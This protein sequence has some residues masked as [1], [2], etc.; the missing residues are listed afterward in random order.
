MQNTAL[1]I[2][3][4]RKLVR[5]ANR[6][7][8]EAERH[9]LAIEQ[10]VKNEPDDAT[11]QALYAI[12]LQNAQVTLERECRR[13][14]SMLDHKAFATPQRA[15][16]KGAA[17]V[18]TSELRFL[19]KQLLGVYSSALAKVKVKLAMVQSTNN[20]P[21]LTAD[22]ISALQDFEK[23][24]LSEIKSPGSPQ[25]SGIKSTSN[26][27][28]TKQALTQSQAVAELE[29]QLNTLLAV[30]TICIQHQGMQIVRHEPAAERTPMAHSDVFA[31][32]IVV[33]SYLAARKQRNASK[34]AVN[35][36]T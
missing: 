22:L 35:R 4:Y 18:D 9:V 5:E 23:G 27:Q 6:L 17:Y 19:R 7:W 25:G 14:A 16:I 1:K 30:K 29:E 32:L 8:T 2:L 11:Q 36:R 33:F 10:R 12:I 24:L 21:R 15:L 20:V 13:I 31:F 34:T 3:E 26:L 28:H